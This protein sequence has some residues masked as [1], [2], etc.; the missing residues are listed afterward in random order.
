MLQRVAKFC[1][2]LA[3]AAALGACALNRSEI[4]IPPQSSA[5]PAAG[6]AVVVL[7]PVDARRFEVAPREPS[8]PS[9]KEPGQINDPQITSRA[10]GRKRNT[11]GAALGDVL[12][13][14]P[15]TAASLVS[16][17]VKAGLR[18]AGYRVVESTDPAAASAAKVNVRIVEFWT[19]VTPGMSIKLDQ[20]TDLTLEGDLPPIRT[21]ATVRFHD[22]KGYFA[23]TESAWMEFIT[24][25]IGK[26]REQVRTLMSPRTAAAAGRD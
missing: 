16:D 7:P 19:W 22:S 5:Q 25:G 23:I 11:Y 14:P 12:L 1:V 9:L 6:V 20:S 2:A 4:T 13:A 3:C 21:P 26:I 10:V 15:Q 18:D 8:I 24:A 17:G